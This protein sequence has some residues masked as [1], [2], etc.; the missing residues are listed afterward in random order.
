MLRAAASI[1][2]AG[3]PGLGAAGRRINAKK[4]KKRSHLGIGLGCGRHVCVRHLFG[5]YLSRLLAEAF[6][7]NP[8]YI[9]E[10]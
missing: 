8:G 6:L 4:R 1:A 7:E 5:G 3:T 9:D 2:S 10:P